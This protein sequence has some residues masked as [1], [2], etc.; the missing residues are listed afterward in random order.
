[1]WAL[2]GRWRDGALELHGGSLAWIRYSAG[3]HWMGTVFT[4]VIFIGLDMPMDGR[5]R[6]CGTLDT[7]CGHS[8]RV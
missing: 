6:F 1:M 7:A 4:K 3:W 5:L 2:G 8:A